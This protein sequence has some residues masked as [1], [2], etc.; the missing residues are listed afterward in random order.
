MTLMRYWSPE[1]YNWCVVLVTEAGEEVC[2]VLDI[3]SHIFT[4][5]VDYDTTV[6]LF[7]V[8]YWLNLCFS[9]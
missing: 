8:S 1:Y 6:S 4:H 9:F 5:F 3:F 7:C 2:T